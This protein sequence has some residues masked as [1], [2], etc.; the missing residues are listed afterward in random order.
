MTLSL[1][2]S[3]LRVEYEVYPFN[4]NKRCGFLK[5]IKHSGNVNDEKSGRLSKLQNWRIGSVGGTGESP[6]GTKYFPEQERQT[7]LQ[8]TFDA[9]LW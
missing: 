5:T 8:V 1:H 3:Q 2:Q 6:P 9:G 7:S 4:P